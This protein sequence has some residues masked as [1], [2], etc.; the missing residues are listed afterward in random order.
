M[1]FS[2]FFVFFLQQYYKIRSQAVDALKGTSEAPYPHKF[3]VSISLTDFIEKYQ[4][5][6]SGTW[7]D[8]VVTV[9]GKLKMIDLLLS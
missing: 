6:E 8:D 1:S 9:S 4:N 2:W 3:S 7:H 5:V